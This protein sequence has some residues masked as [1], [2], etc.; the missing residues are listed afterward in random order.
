MFTRVLVHALV[1]ELAETEIIHQLT[2]Q[3][4][5]SFLPVGLR[6]I[7]GATSPQRINLLFIN[8]GRIRFV[9]CFAMNSADRI[10]DPV[11]KI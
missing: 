2:P 8:P 4:D 6:R 11:L 1:T 3:A 7:H 10:S 5:E 9:P